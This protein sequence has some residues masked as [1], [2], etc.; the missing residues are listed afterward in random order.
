[1]ANPRLQQI[2]ALIKA[3]DM[4]RARELLRAELKEH[5]TADAWCLA[6]YVVSSPRQKV[7]FLE[8]ALELDPFHERAHEL[9]EKY[10]ETP[11]QHF[12]EKTNAASPIPEEL[13]MLNK[14]IHIF[15]KYDWK[16][17]LSSDTTKQFE[18]KQNINCLAALSLIILFPI[19]G[20]IIVV[21]SAL[22]A[23]FETITLQT[24][25][26]G[27]LLGTSSSKK[28]QYRVLNII[29]MEKLAKSGK[30]E[31]EKSGWGKALISFLIVLILILSLIMILS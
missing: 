20:L 23:P 26:R 11:A 6:T 13:Q 30:I 10:Q 2:S 4:D 15:N 29:D 24:T 8:K 12:P 25:G 3:G 21:L 7:L 28:E 5:P 31:E 27:Y 17:S 19:I 16:L 18:K 14:S 22:L 9:M 1:M